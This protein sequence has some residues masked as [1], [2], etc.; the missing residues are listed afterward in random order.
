MEVGARCIRVGESKLSSQFH[1][2][3]EI[4]ADVM[5]T[6]TEVRN[7]TLPIGKEN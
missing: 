3:L 7:M 4:Q 2:V 5:R 6:R 1:I